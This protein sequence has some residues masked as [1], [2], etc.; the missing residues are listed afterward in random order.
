[1][2]YFSFTSLAPEITTTEAPEITT[3]EAPETTT[4]GMSN[5]SE[6]VLNEIEHDSDNYEGQSLCYL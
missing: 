4:E 1:M 5:V 3:T 2:A 6:Q